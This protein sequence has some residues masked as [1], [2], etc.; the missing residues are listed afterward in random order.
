MQYTA[1]RLKDT[2][3]LTKQAVK[4]Q[5]KLD[6]IFGKVITTCD[7]TI[8]VFWSNDRV[9]WHPPSELEL[10]LPLKK[11]KGDFLTEAMLIEEGL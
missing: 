8:Q 7:G 4:A 6:C 11:G 10:V 3:R 9:L 2:V 1:I 5:P